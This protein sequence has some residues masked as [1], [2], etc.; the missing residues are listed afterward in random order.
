MANQ[1]T[2]TSVPE[3]ARGCPAG[4]HLGAV[5]RRVGWPTRTCAPEKSA[6]PSSRCAQLDQ[7]AGA[8]TGR[9]GT[10][11][12]WPS[13]PHICAEGWR[14]ADQLTPMISLEDGKKRGGRGTSVPQ[15]GA[16][17]GWPTSH[18]DQ[19]S[20][21]SSPA[22]SHRCAEGLRH[23]GARGQRL[24]LT[25]TSAPYRTARGRPADVCMLARWR[26]GG[27]RPQTSG[28]WVAR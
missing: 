25:R 17:P 26:R 10:A 8:G 18:L 21:R 20:A 15:D 12:G 7:R 16:G 9:L 11:R 14:E 13:I 19:G 28:P 22:D 27:D 3:T 5:G 23:I 1:R 2:R 4:T 6:W 24:L